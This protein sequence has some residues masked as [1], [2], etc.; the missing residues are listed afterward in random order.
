MVADIEHYLPGLNFDFPIIPYEMFGWAGARS[1]N[2]GIQRGGR[3]HKAPR[4][5]TKAL[6][7]LGE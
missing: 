4:D 7:Y 5:V 2:K 6:R 1:G 3:S